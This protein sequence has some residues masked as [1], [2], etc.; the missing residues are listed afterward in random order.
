MV[1]RILLVEDTDPTLLE[2][3]DAALRETGYDVVRRRQGDAQ[4]T[5]S[6]T[7]TDLVFIDL[8]LP[9]AVEVCEGIREDPDG[10]IVP[11][12]F[13]GTGDE[14]VQSPADALSHGGDFFFRH[15][16]HVESVLT[17]VKTYIGEG[18][19]SA[20]ATS[21]P[22]SPLAAD[23]P[24][25][26]LFEVDDAPAPA[27]EGASTGVSS[28]PGDVAADTSL[29]L[30]QFSWS[31]DDYPDLDTDAVTE[32]SGLAD[33]ADA[34][35]EDIKTREHELEAEAARAQAET[36][37][38]VRAEAEAEARRR[39]E[40]E[41][42]AEAAVRAQAEEK[43]RAEAEEK[44]R[45]EEA[46]ALAEAEE[47]AR[48]EASRA[49]VAAQ[50]RAEAEE[51]ARAEAA[52]QARAET[53]EK[54]REEAAARAR[55]EAER[56]RAREE[57]EEAAR[58]RQ[59]EEEEEA[60]RARQREEEEEAAR[61]R[62]REEEEEAVRARQR[63]EEEAARARQRAEKEEEAR[64]AAEAETLRRRAELEARRQAEETA[65]QQAEEEIA[66]RHAEAEARKQAEAEARRRAEEAARQRAEEEAQAR[67]AEDARRRAEESA[68]ERE[69]SEVRPQPPPLPAVAVTDVQVRET[70]NAGA[71]VDVARV[72]DN[73][74]AFDKQ[75]D[76]AEAMFRFHREGFTGRVDFTAGERQKV[77]FFEQ[78]RPVQI[79]SSQA[80]DRMEEYLYREGKITRTQYQS[81]RVKRLEGPRRIGAYL[82]TEG[83]LKPEELF[84]VVRGHLEE[85]LYG[86]YEWD[87][88]SFT[89]S[90]ER[91]PEDERVMLDLDPRR[92][93]FE[94]IRRK[95]LMPRLMARVGG[96]SSLLAPVPEMALDAEALGLSAEERQLCRL[97]D[98]TRSV[99]DLVFSTGLG[100][101]RTYQLLLGLMVIQ[102]AQVLVRGIES[103]DMDSRGYADAIDRERILDKVEQ[104]RKL[105]Y[106]QI[107]GVPRNATPYE[108]TRAHQRILKEFDPDRYGDAIRGDLHDE[109]LEINRVLDDARQVLADE[110][111][112]QAYA[113]HLI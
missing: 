92:L 98:G 90:A 55:V 93:I 100:E 70:S 36:E 71:G 51:R 62:Q 12:I 3:V 34:L 6:Q 53:E 41:A 81:V 4:E 28:A 18:L 59:R 91:A 49:E 23:S 21:P 109:L 22:V 60:A 73:Y 56:Q 101:L 58:V 25:S 96:P 40:E 2:P 77:I 47:K 64:Q 97:L 78:G 85:G 10:A 57:E 43:A 72:R 111:L 5:F 19:G 67:A 94:G 13:I 102:Y 32:S 15:P 107:L 87:A 9:A 46:A 35:L 11:I 17:K 48:E 16:V 7:Q 27:V 54:A 63:E 50:E 14:A 75:R 44:A 8:R 24:V 26:A 30:P 86:L 37:A 83:Y 76:I 79:H 105:D 106:F 84:A 20:G 45:G 95:Y 103:S 108:I 89:V 52:A 74:G 110:D 82:L 80:F 66:R 33:A 112:R 113:R 42:K 31:S 29:G 65:R 99:E 88:G 61:A 1:K 68:R 38:R 69:S 39:A 104:V